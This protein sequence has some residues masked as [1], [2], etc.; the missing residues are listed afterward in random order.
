M[1][2][3]LEWLWTN[4]EEVASYILAALVASTALVHILQRAAAAFGRLALKTSTKYDDYAAQKLSKWL[5]WCD[6]A[7]LSLS[8][9]LPHVGVKA[10]KQWSQ[11]ER[12][13]RISEHPD[14]E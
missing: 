10:R 4:R 3:N 9:W 14:A 1:Q 2:A 8:K 12:D 6:T 5:A 7:L 13:A 11:A